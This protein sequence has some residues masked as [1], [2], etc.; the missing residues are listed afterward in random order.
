MLYVGIGLQREHPSACVVKKKSKGNE[1]VHRVSPGE[2]KG[3]TRKWPAS[4]HWFLFRK[5]AMPLFLVLLIL[6]LFSR[7]FGEPVTVQQVVDQFSLTNYQDLLFNRL[8]TSEGMKRSCLRRYQHDDCRDMI[9]TNLQSLGLNPYLDAFKFNGG[10]D[11]TLDAWNVVAIKPGL[12]NPSNE[13]YIVSGHYDSVDNPGAD[14]DA[15]GVACVLEMARVL[16][17]FQFARTIVFIAFDAEERVDSVT[18]VLAPGSARYVSQHLQDNIRGMVSADMIGHQA[19]G[20]Y[21]NT[22]QIEGSPATDPIRNDVLAAVAEYGQGLRAVITTEPGE[23]DHCVFMDAGFQ[24]CC[25]AEA[26]HSQNPFQHLL[27]DYATRPGNIDVAYAGRM[28]RSI[29]GFFTTRLEP[30]D[31]AAE[32]LSIACRPDGAAAIQFRGLPGAKYATEFSPV[33][34][35]GSW[36]SLETNVASADLG[37][38]QT[39]DPRGAQGEAGF[40]R[41]RFVP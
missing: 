18:Q 1:K 16:S 9:F 27:T 35:G 25:L 21:S 29:I 12:R 33:L 6:S 3:N 22:A 4:V 11:G 34:A 2:S 7:A 39:I 26:N 40:Y 20:S 23:S 13:I 37:T 19:S 24:A 36:N 5:T 32:A 15:S 30:L 17:Q 41:A 38:F 31:V 28:C 8:Y 10:S 14:D